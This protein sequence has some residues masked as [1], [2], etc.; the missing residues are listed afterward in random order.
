[1]DY[2][3][4][5]LGPPPA[6]PTAADKAAAQDGT[7]T[8]EQRERLRAWREYWAGGYEA[9]EK[10]FKGGATLD[11]LGYQDVQGKGKT[12]WNMYGPGGLY[13]AYGGDVSGEWVY[14][15]LRGRKKKA[16]RPGLEQTGWVP[17]DPSEQSGYAKWERWQGKNPGASYR[18]FMANQ[19]IKQ[20][21]HYG[22]YIPQGNG[23][24]LDPGRALFDKYFNVLQTFNGWKSP[25]ANLP[26]A[27]NLPPLMGGQTQGGG[28][29]GTTQTGPDD[30]GNPRG[31]GNFGTP[32]PFDKARWYD[33]PRHWLFDSQGGG[34]G[35][36][37]SPGGPNPGPTP[38]PRPSPTPRPGGPKGVLWPDF[39]AKNSMAPFGPM[40]GAVAPQLEIPRMQ[41]N[42]GSTLF[43]AQ[44]NTGQGQGYAAGYD[45]PNVW[46]N[47]MS[48]GG[49]F[50]GPASKSASGNQF[51]AFSA[52]NSL[53]PSQSSGGARDIWG[54]WSKMNKNI[55]GSAWNKNMWGGSR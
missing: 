31:P 46:A 47:F 45:M 9:V 26:Y 53:F 21:V 7:A 2:I 36:A 30:P 13:S 29:G 40:T 6:R 42:Q 25:W 51:D 22:H 15:W 8:P 3:E 1:M 34:S 43:P 32:D 28:G 20:G 18:D 50:G 54:D 14:D 48:G 27:A 35:N 33:G 49:G 10:A 23:T 37:G 19:G 44:L 17:I 4:S 5:Q 41:A 16:D 52:Y 12:L 55:F 38:S 24:F 11:Q 39:A